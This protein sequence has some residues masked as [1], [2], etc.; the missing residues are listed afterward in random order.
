MAMDGA[1]RGWPETFAEG[2]KSAAGHSSD[3]PPS[4]S[5]LAPKVCGAPVEECC[6][7]SWTAVDAAVMSL[8]PEADLELDLGADRHRLLLLLEVVG[9][10][11]AVTE[12]SP[13]VAPPRSSH[14]LSLI[15]RYA[16]VRGRGCGVRFL[17]LLALDFDEGAVERMIDGPGPWA[18]RLMFA[19]VRLRQLSLLL[20]QECANDEPTSRLYADALSLALIQRLNDLSAPH[21][22]LERGGLPPFKLRRVTEYMREHVGD[23]IGMQEVAG[24]AG[25]SASYFSRAFKNSTGLSPHQWLILARCERA[26]FLLLETEGTLA[27]IALEVG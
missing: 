4:H 7:A 5:G 2:A 8:R 16:A 27:E 3:A 26:K 22:S 9:G 6:A 15:P 12:G 21:T 10:R 19:D 18:Q 14:V 23:D 11:F 24:L 1:A 13:P 17:R 20:A 25:M